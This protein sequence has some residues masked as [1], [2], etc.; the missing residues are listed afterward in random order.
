MVIIMF[1]TLELKK[2]GGKGKEIF[3]EGLM[4]SKISGKDLGPPNSQGRTL[5][6]TIN[7]HLSTQSLPSHHTLHCFLLF[8]N[9]AF[10]FQY[11]LSLSSYIAPATWLSSFISKITLVYFFFT[12]LLCFQQNTSFTFYLVI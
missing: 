4:S 2:K 7:S 12:T 5:R 11:S 1:G 9:I 8:L 3:R 10:S 6:P